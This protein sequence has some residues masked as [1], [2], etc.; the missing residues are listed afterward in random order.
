MASRITLDRTNY[1]SLMRWNQ[2]LAVRILA[3]A[4][5]TLLVFSLFTMPMGKVFLPNDTAASLGTGM[6]LG[7]ILSDITNPT[8]DFNLLAKDHGRPF[9]MNEG[10]L[11]GNVLY[12]KE[13]FAGTVFVTEDGLTY[14][15]NT[16][17][18]Q[19]GGDSNSPNAVAIK[20]SFV[21]ANKLQIRGYDQSQAKINYFAGDQS[22]WR[23][24]IPAFN[25][26]SLG[27]VWDGISVDLN[28]RNNNVEKIFTVAPGADIK[29][30]RLGLDGVTDIRINGE[31][32]LVLSTEL[33]TVSLTKPVA[34]QEIGL[35]G[36]DIQASYVVLDN[37]K[38]GFAVGSEYDPLYPLIIDPLLASTYIGGTDN[39]G[40]SLL[41]PLADD[42]DAGIAFD[43]DGNV[44]LTG[45]TISDDYP[46]TVG[47][48][49]APAGTLPD[50]V[51]SKFNSDLNYLVASAV[52]GGGQLDE[53]LAIAIDSSDNI[54]ITGRTNSS[55]FPTTVGAFNETYSGGLSDAFVSILSNDL[56][57]LDSSTFIGGNAMDQARAIAINAAGD[58]YIVGNSASVNYPTTVGAF[59]TV[60]D[61]VSGP[62]VVVTKFPSDLD[63]L[64]A[65]TFIG[66]SNDSVG[67]GVDFGP[68]GEVYVTGLTLATD[69]PMVGGYDTTKS[70]ANQHDTF[71]ASFTSDL[72]DLLASTY[73]G[74]GAIGGEHTTPFGIVVEPSG[75]Y[76]A[77][78]TES[79][80]FPTTMG[81]Y[82]ETHNGQLDVYISVLPLTLDSLQA[83]TVIGGVNNEGANGLA[84]TDSSVYV[85]SFGGTG[86]PTTSGAFNEGVNDAYISQLDLDLTTLL[87]S[88]SI[89]GSNT[90]IP[91]SIA[92]DASGG[93]YIAGWTRSVD[94]P[95]ATG[96]YDSIKAGAAGSF[97]FIVS[98]L[99][100]DLLADSNPPVSFIEIEGGADTTTSSEVA[101]SLSCD[102]E[103]RCAEIRLTFANV[104]ANTS[105][106]IAD[107][108]PIEVLS[109]LDPAPTTLFAEETDDNT[110]VFELEIVLTSDGT[111]DSLKFSNGDSIDATGAFFDSAENTKTIDATFTD[112]DGNTAFASDDILF[113]DPGFTFFEQFGTASD[114]MV[115][116][117]AADSTGV[118]VVGQTEGD[119]EGTSAGSADAF[120]RKYSLDGTTVLWAD[121]FGTPSND[122]A[123]AVA[124]DST[125]VYVA[126]HTAGN[127]EGTNAGAED[128]FIRKYN[129]DGSMIEWTT[130]FGTSA[131]DAARGIA[132][133]STG[134]YVVGDT[135]GDLE[136]TNSGGR[137]PFIRKYNLDGDTII[138]TDQFGGSGPDFGLAVAADSTGP[139]AVGTI[140]QADAFVYKYNPSIGELEWFAEFGTPALDFA[141][142][143]AVDSTGVYVAGRTEGDLEGTNE[144]I[145]DAYLRK[146]NLDGTAIQWTDQFGTLV[147]DGAASVAVDPTGVYV[148]GDTSDAAFIRGYSHDGSTIQLDEE[149]SSD[150]Y[151][152]TSAAGVALGSA[153]VGGRACIGDGGECNGF[154]ARFE[155]ADNLPP[156]IT[157]VSDSPDPFSPN[158]DSVDDTTTVTFTSDEAGT[159]TLQILNA[160]LMGGQNITG[161]MVAGVNNVVWDG[162]GFTTTTVPDGT[163]SYLIE[164][165]DASGNRAHEGI[166]MGTY[167]IT[168]DAGASAQPTTL[169]LNPLRDI[170][171]TTGFTV[172]GELVIEDT[173]EG[174]SG[175]QID[176]TGTGVTPSLQSVMTEGVTFTGVIDL[177]SCE[178]P[179]VPT[180]TTCTTDD[181]GMDD[182]TSD[183]I[184]LHLGV[185]GKIMF[186]AG[187]VTAKIYLQDMGTS[188]FK[189]VVE[190]RNGALQTE[191][192]SAGAL[193]PIVPKIEIISGYTDGDPNGL[194]ELTITEITG[195]SSV[196]IAAVLTGNPDGL[197]VE[198]HQINFEEFT[199]GPQTSPF[200]V[201]PGFFFSTGFAQNI[202]EEGLDIT[203]HYAGTGAFAPSDSAT[204][205]YNVLA[206]TAGLGG[207]GSNS[208]VGD[209]GTSITTLDCNTE[210][211]SVDTDNDGICDIW[212][213]SGITLGG[214]FYQ[215]VGAVVGQKDI[216]VEIDCMTGF[217]P[218]TSGSGINNNIQTVI[219]VFAAE[220]FALHITVDETN[221][222]VF[223]PLHVWT[224]NTPA[225]LDDFDSIKKAKFGTSQE[226][227]GV[228]LGN[229]NANLRAKAQ[230]YHY[231]LFAKN[232]NTGTQTAC[233]PSGQAE[234]SGNDFIVSVGCTTSGG[235]A[236]SNQERIG[237]LMH[238]LGHN[239]GLRH[240]GGDD[241]NCKPNLISVMS[242]A[243]QFPWGSLAATTSSGQRTEWSPTYS[244][245]DLQTLD[246]NALLESN[247]LTITTSQ[248]NSGGFSSFGPGSSSFEIIWGRPA[249]TYGVTGA[250]VNWNNAA[251]NTAALN[252]N[253]LSGMTGCSGTLK[254]Q[255]ES[256]DEWSIM[257]LNFRDAGTI[258]GLTYP[259]PDTLAELTP[260]VLEGAEQGSIVGPNNVFNNPGISVLPDVATDAE[261]NIYV[262][263]SEKPGPVSGNFEILFSKSVDGGATFSA[264]EIVSNNAGDS[265][266]PRIAV[267][268][269]ILYVVWSD[270]TAGTSNN[271]D[272]RFSKSSNMG[273]DWDP[274]VKLSSNSGDSLTPS[275]AAS[276]SSI[277]VVWSD[278]TSG[279]SGKFDIQFKKSTDGGT[280]FTPNTASGT[281]VS[282]NGGDSLTPDVEVSANGIFVVWSDT[283]GGTSGKFDILF[284]KSTDGGL[285]FLPNT[286]NA[287]NISTNSGFSLTPSLGV[288]GNNVYVTWSDTTGGTSG[289]FDILFKKST[290]GGTNFT[291][292]TANAKNISTT[293]SLSATPR[294]A[295][296]SGSIYIAWS[297]IGAPGQFDIFVKK[298]GDA[299]ENFEAAVNISDN[300]GQSIT[301]AIAVT[302]VL[303]L[304]WGD[305]T[306]GITGDI[307][308]ASRI[309]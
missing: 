125:G 236:N 91:A 67:Q 50:V 123:N 270:K 289:N 38:Y 278:K 92:I 273:D 263:W 101:V 17:Q 72:T 78:R 283:S 137:D 138:G 294:I 65:S 30:I 290:D 141:N 267:S 15:L 304:V 186:P 104:G 308:Y 177:A 222:S 23:T 221:L 200:T 157:A 80:D 227:A 106:I 1:E 36:R 120:I 207:E 288:D 274:S 306:P 166:P 44:F 37:S 230:V 213:Q 204:E 108:I 281:K 5:C 169:T 253:T 94:Y 238:E 268:D 235:F 147:D 118:Y 25:K 6:P 144:G 302:D 140:A 190:E 260:P 161:A 242:Y 229:G 206:N 124:V 35:E 133:D 271:Y 32:E 285:T 237:T 216:F 66:G 277:Y 247:G 55:D 228:T 279:T 99:T 132:V 22:S 42:E 40:N 112:G 201:N 19:P 178:T 256:Y 174:I 13:T 176:F 43:S 261:N 3:P 264:P 170:T 83:S 309:V 93:V 208:A 185:G 162:S 232:I 258:D 182:V 219:N 127:L 234:L 150:D 192:T 239:L 98:K 287:K 286:A 95:I 151:D 53:A 196:G 51:I 62:A 224:D 199:A 69:F 134:V 272:I 87:A 21:D 262:V 81:A 197:P 116:G 248:W 301:P 41:T 179:A 243:R 88:T 54:Y 20:E 115:N 143:V 209:T 73:H 251:G 180:P 296:S 4:L 249:V 48:Y 259:D 305:L 276:G 82:D 45:L 28:A 156:V 26:V 18:V 252:L 202:D 233:G 307:M 255:L 191:A 269:G 293:S 168:V 194:K 119:L 131:S 212:E 266:T 34:Y 142:G 117:V 61:L 111:S 130:Q 16:N 172:S 198:L 89:G 126:G 60:N 155:T 75:V 300:S 107:E 146:Y 211:G 145:S 113:D 298:S 135:A 58:V 70:G 244:R 39:E 265:L 218:T 86:Y 193:S 158:D 164:A 171:A 291:P 188:S 275:I 85:T 57:S 303:H 148:V 210:V 8:S 163:Y 128:A 49:G 195:G 46:T 56:S 139:Y 295:V 96:A 217:C 9:V 11:D 153:F 27:E 254:S 84:V 241:D 284:K 297:D 102:D 33:G 103:G 122:V 154:L 63:G 246:E 71:I 77:G 226:R 129:L 159:F 90:D 160:T 59:D 225:V 121:Q 152:F 12:Y 52:I 167:T 79:A 189:Y 110:A 205:T 47:P 14:A 292:N 250:S 100:G 76:I 203:A 24:N 299:G 29:D 280:S 64:S 149:F 231:G 165:D 105:P 214:G 97:D 181:I 10:Q 2:K 68:L 31:G 240:G 136:G 114:D 245:Q 175:Q 187:T 173:G 7:F 257:D 109:D 220:G 223:D 184:V 282:N 183:N 215:L 74:N